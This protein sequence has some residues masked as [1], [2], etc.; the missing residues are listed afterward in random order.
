MKAAQRAI[1]SREFA[2][3]WAFDRISPIG[4]RRSD[5]HAALIASTI[6]NCLTTGRRKTI[7]DFI[8]EYG[9]H[10]YPKPEEVEKKAMAMAR[11]MNERRAKRGNDR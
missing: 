1:S 2:E 3:W 10:D 4:G 9:G 8:L 11:M 5:L 7:D 6:A